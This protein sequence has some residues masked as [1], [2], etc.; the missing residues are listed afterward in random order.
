M[1]AS[2][3]NI[4]HELP[5]FSFSDKKVASI[6]PDV[7]SMIEGAEIK[8]VNFSKNAL[9]EWPEKYVLAVPGS[10]STLERDNI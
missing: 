7:W 10:S 2:R 6:S 4:G 8:K 5:F 9:P 3:Q 1:P